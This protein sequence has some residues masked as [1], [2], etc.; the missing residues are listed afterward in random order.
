MPYSAKVVESIEPIMLQILI[1]G[2]IDLTH[3][4]SGYCKQWRTQ[5]F[6]MGEDGGVG[7][8]V[9]PKFFFAIY[10]LANKQLIAMSQDGIKVKQCVMQ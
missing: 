2:K 6:S 5:D 8:K 1:D 9:T 4:L 3:P 10:T 7:F